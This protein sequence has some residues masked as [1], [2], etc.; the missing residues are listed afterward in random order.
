ME[1]TLSRIAHAPE[2]RAWILIGE[3]G[4]AFKDED[5]EDRR[6]AEKRRAGELSPRP[7]VRSGVG[8]LRYAVALTAAD[9]GTTG[10]RAR[11]SAT[12]AIT[13]RTA[14]V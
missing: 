3:G 8:E 2:E 14:A 12:S 10:R 4:L 7:P 9:A 5:H 6:W 1:S 13:A 11:S